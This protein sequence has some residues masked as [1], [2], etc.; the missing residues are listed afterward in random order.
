MIKILV[1]Y[2]TKHQATAEI[3]TVIAKV[4]KQATRFDV[5]I[6]AI[7]NIEF[8]AGYDAV[9]LGSAVYKGNWRPAAASFLTLHAQE[10]AQIPVWLFSSGP[11][12]EGDPKD[13]MEGWEFPPALRIIAAQ[14]SPRDM[15]IFH[16]K[17][18]VT[19]LNMLEQT[20]VKIVHAPLGDFRDWMKIEQWATNIAQVLH[21]ENSNLVSHPNYA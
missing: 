15:A 11:T 9:V 1:A 6:Q 20:A 10:L 4:L 5:D 17:L 19:K 2:A 13:I 16:G 8:I 3:A 21:D 12:G 7:D 14:I 18:D